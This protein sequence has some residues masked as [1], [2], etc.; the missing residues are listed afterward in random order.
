[1][2]LSLSTL[3]ILACFHHAGAA[4]AEIDALP[5]VDVTATWNDL[6]KQPPITL[7]NGATLRLG[8]ETLA[9]PAQRGAMI[10]LLGEGEIVEEKDRS[11]EPLGPLT[12]ELLQPPDGKRLE[13]KWSL[14]ACRIVGT[15]PITSLRLWT[16]RISAP[17][18]TTVTWLAR[19][20]QQPLA[21]IRFHA[22]AEPWQPW[23]PLCRPTQKQDALK[24]NGELTIA[25][26]T[27]PTDE[28]SHDYGAVALIG[29]DAVA[30]QPLCDGRFPW[31]AL[32]VRLIECPALA[33]AS[34]PQLD[35][36]TATVAAWR[37][38]DRIHL[39]LPEPIDSGHLREHVLARWWLNGTAVLPAQGPIGGENFSGMTQITSHLMFSF[40]GLAPGFTAPTGS[41]V[42]VEFL[43]VPQGWER[44]DGCMHAMHAQMAI[45]SA[46][47]APHPAPHPGPQR[48]NRLCWTMPQ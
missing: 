33:A 39:A 40:A 47:V 3:V 30:A 10:Y 19:L 8:I 21:R 20:K 29:P 32:P 1:M 37:S 48:S 2:R 13:I 6:A 22:T 4:E 7:A 24:E 31:L 5:L 18:G 34:L 38:G 41:E 44:E 46:D 28:G 35:P 43:V 12:L 26:S 36:A 45:R 27:G 11:D 42:A 25:A 15:G 23:S 16:R 14:F 9:A 17:A